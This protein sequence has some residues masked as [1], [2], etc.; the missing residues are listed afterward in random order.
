MRSEPISIRHR[1][2]SKIRPKL[3]RLGVLT[4]ARKL[5]SKSL[6]TKVTTRIRLAGFDASAVGATTMNQN[7][8]KRGIRHNRKT[9]LKVDGINFV[10]DLRV[11]IGLGESS[12]LLVNAA[13]HARIPVAYSEVAL[14]FENRGHDVIEN[15][16]QGS[17]YSFTISSQRTGITSRL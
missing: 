4:L 17:P 15:L 1:I 11:D 8:M 5:F 14:A 12:R 13:C 9:A 2:Y 10:G 7:I 6:R 3:Y 16:A